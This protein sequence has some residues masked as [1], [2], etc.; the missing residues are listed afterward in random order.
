[1]KENKKIISP[2][3]FKKKMKEIQIKL[4]AGFLVLDK[5]EAHIQMDDLMCE[6]LS[7]LGYKEGIEIF[8]NTEKYYA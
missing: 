1:M 7:S 6:V 3:E 2:D 8:Q 5:E 4:D